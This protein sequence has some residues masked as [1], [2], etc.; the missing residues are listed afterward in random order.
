MIHWAWLIAAAFGG[1]M[2]GALMLGICAAAGIEGAYHDG[3]ARG[4]DVGT[5]TGYE[6]ALLDE[7]V[8]EE[9]A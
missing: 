1:V 5:R 7:V 9:A 4:L 2:A 3:Y 8:R 6:A